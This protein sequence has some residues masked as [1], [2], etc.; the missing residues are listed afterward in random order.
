MML[1]VI[2]TLVSRWMGFLNARKLDEELDG[3]IESHLAMLAEENMRRGMNADEARDAARREFGNITQLAEKHREARGLPRLETF[4]QD[5]RY[6]L[7]MLRK[8][9]VFTAVAVLTLG[10]EIGLNTTLF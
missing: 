10:F 4:L 7:R 5:L 9:P 2:R 6:A 8:S 3:E 1:P